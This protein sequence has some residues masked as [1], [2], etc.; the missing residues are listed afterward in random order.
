M[1]QNSKQ[2]AAIPNPSLKPLSVLVGDYQLPITIYGIRNT[3]HQLRIT[4]LHVLQRF[5]IP[6][7]R[8]GRLAALAGG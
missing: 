7:D 3:D 8:N 6:L 2:A 5:Q 4:H 1:P